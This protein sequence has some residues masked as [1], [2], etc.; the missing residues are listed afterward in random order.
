MSDYIEWCICVVKQWYV[1]DTAILSDKVVKIDPVVVD[2]FVYYVNIP[3]K[4]F[5]TC[6]SISA[7]LGIYL[8]I[9]FS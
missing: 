9:K 3:L 8:F 2:G 6:A 5:F 7:G 4:V 1:E